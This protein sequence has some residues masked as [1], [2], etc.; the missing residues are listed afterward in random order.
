M[1]ISLFNRARE[2]FDRQTTILA[3]NESADAPKLANVRTDRQVLPRFAD[4]VL[5]A[6]RPRAKL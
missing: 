5:A 3:E 2:S 1:K 4:D 6:Q